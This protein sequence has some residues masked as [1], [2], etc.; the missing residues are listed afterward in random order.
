MFLVKRGESR[1]FDVF[2]EIF[3][4]LEEREKNVERSWAEGKFQKNV[5]PPRSGACL[6]LFI[7]SDAKTEATAIVRPPVAFQEMPASKLF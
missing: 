7:A 1:D 5:C 2:L 6:G 4:C 3:W